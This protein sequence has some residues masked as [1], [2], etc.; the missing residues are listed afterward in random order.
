MTLDNLNN[1]RREASRYF[2]DKKEEY[3][4]DIFHEL[5]MNSKNKNVRDLCRGINEFKRGCQPRSNL[6][7]D[8]NGELFA[9]FHNILNR[10]KNYSSQ[11]LSVHNVSDVTQIEVHA[12]EPLLLLCSSRFEV[13][14]AIVKLKKY[15]SQGSDQ[16][17]AELIQAGD[18]PQSRQFYLE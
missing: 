15:K 12:A 18:D 13:E 14:I 3:L 9:D 6:V 11:L 2:R 8:E 1:I 7:K 5:S 16:I 4:N 10:W 17:P